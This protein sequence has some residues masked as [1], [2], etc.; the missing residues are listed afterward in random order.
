MG[1]T[2]DAM[3]ATLR[4]VAEYE[5]YFREAFGTAEITKERV[6]KA[7]ADYERTR[8]S[9]N[10]PWDRWRK[11]RDENAVS[12]EVKRG[13]EL[14]FG[15]A[16]CS[17][18]HSGQN[19]TDS[20]FHNVGVG[21][22]A[23]TERF[24]DEGRYVVTKKETDRGAFKTPTVRDVILHS[25]YMHDGSVATLH[26]VVELYN[27]AGIKNPHLDPKVQPL[28]LNDDEVDALVRFMEALTGEG[29]RET[30][31]AAFPGIK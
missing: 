7:I 25:P 8:M 3:V 18:C 20:L 1:N 24:A 31:P 10:S 16:R 4:R 26:E 6:A 11:N 21:W 22:N 17:Q 9:G 29:P 13:H 27:R 23:E 2:H 12:A 14:F 30:P 28:N 5:P 19:L 15:K